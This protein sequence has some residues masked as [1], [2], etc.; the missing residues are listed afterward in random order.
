MTNYDYDILTIG[1]GP[2]GMVVSAMGAEMGLKVCAI[3]KNKL[4]GECMNVGCIPSKALLR[5]AKIR[6]AVTKFS[7][8]DMEEMPLPAVKNPFPHIQEKLDYINNKKYAVKFEKVDKVLRQGSASFVDSHTV[9]VGDRKITAKRIF[10]CTGTKPSKPPIP[11]LDTIDNIL[12]NENLF[13]L[14]SIPESMLIIGGGAI[15][16]EMAQAFSRLGCKTTIV[17]MDPHLL[18]FA[19]R[20]AGEE[21]EATFK[22][23]GIEVYNSRSISQV[24]AKNGR[25]ILKTKEGETLKAER[26]LLAAGRVPTLDGLNLEKAG[27]NYSPKGIPVNGNLETNVSHIYA[28]GDCNSNYLFSHAAM[29]QGMIALMNIMRPWPFKKDFRKYVVPWTVFTEPQV[30][31][32]GMKESELIAPGIKYDVIEAKHADYGAAIAE[33]VTTGSVRVLASKMGKI[34]GVSVVGE[35]SAEMI[36]EWALAIQKKIRLADIMLL[37]HSFP[38]MSFM[39]KSIGES[40]MMNMLKNSTMKKMMGFMMR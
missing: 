13:N 2:A 8:F 14:E 28:V 36:N 12:T 21:L 35:G 31:S 20:F 24:E 38:S 4:G 25:V 3:E 15:G 19:D 1:V 7:D 11:G 34:Y 23:E 32:V 9:A 16:S 33:Q 30:S 10:I 22:K 27:V 5:M 39:N 26:L 37:Q 6:H 40:W 17:Q 18:P 29:H